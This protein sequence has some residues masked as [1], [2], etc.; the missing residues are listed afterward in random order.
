MRVPYAH[1]TTYTQSIHF[2]CGYRP[3]ALERRHETR[4]AIKR[5]SKFPRNSLGFQSDFFDRLPNRNNALQSQSA[6]VS[7]VTVGDILDVLFM[8]LQILLIN[9]TAVFSS[10]RIKCDLAGDRTSRQCRIERCQ[11]NARC[12]KL[13]PL[14]HQNIDLCLQVRAPRVKRRI[15]MD[16]HEAEASDRVPVVFFEDPPVDG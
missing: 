10:H 12:R 9:D 1:Q 16:A 5:D 4:I 7:N 15:G 11:H 8:H 6:S 3:I 14:P 13:A 2:L